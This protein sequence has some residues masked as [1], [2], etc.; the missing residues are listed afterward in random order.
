MKF[1]ITGQCP[2]GKNSV[3]VTRTGKRFPSKRFKEWREKAM[4]ELLSQCIPD[5]PISRP[6]SVTVEYWASDNRRRDV[7]GILDALWHLLEKVKIV[8]DDAYLGGR[9]CE[10][11]F[12]NWGKGVNSGVEIDIEI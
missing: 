10:V 8:A 9:D 12:I 5:E 7:P 1:V 2:S 6:V 11:K 3:I 4:K